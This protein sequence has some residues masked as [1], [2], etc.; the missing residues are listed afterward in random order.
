MAIRVAKVKGSKK[1]RLRYK[2]KVGAG[3]VVACQVGEGCRLGTQK[4]P[5]NPAHGTNTFGQVYTKD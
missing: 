5:S 3:G 2:A 4:H 1:L